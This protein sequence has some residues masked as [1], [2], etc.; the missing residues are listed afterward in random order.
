VTAVKQ[1]KILFNTQF[2]ESGFLWQQY[3]HICDRSPK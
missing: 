3:W 1:I 2:V